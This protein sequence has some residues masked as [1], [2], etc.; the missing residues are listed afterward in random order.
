MR[1]GREHPKVSL[2]NGKPE[3]VEVPQTSY[4]MGH[5]SQKKVTLRGQCSSLN[6]CLY[7]QRILLNFGV[8]YGCFRK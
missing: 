3:G 7:L 2:K 6:L 5:T 4:S 8:E 1:L